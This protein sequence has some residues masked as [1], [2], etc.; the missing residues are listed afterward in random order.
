MSYSS[1]KLEESTASDAFKFI[2]ILFWIDGGIA[3]KWRDAKV[4]ADKL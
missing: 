2:P 1:I 4:F 3:K